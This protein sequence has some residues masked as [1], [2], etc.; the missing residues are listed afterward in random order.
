[1]KRLGIWLSVTVGAIVLAVAALLWF[2]Q[3]GSPSTNTAAAA[4]NKAASAN[5]AAQEEIQFVSR[6]NGWI[7]V[8][9]R[10]VP[11]LSS[12]LSLPVSGVVGELL[13]NEGDTVAANQ[14][15]LRL[16]SQQQAIA[17]TQAAAQ[18]K[19]AEARLAELK[20]GARSEDLKTALAG[21]VAAQARQ[22][23]PSRC[24]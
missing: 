23:S 24:T 16:R 18:L 1:M 10:V 19:Q 15:L 17:V 3:P 2:T 7:E 5:D 12:N 14:P 21:L 20:A 9:G 13:V 11:V 6:N 22:S 4:G 8:D